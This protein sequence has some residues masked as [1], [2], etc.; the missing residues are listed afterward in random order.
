MAN[1]P[2]TKEFNQLSL[3]MRLT[4]VQMLNSRIG[5]IHSVN[6]EGENVCQSLHAYGEHYIEATISI[7]MNELMNILAFNKD[8]ERMDKYLEKVSLGNLV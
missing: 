1:N 8:D 2:T 7:D 3:D 4:I 6:S 5:H